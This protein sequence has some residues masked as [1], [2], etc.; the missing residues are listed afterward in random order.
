MI[1]ERKRRKKDGHTGCWSRGKGSC[2]CALYG[3]SKNKSKTT[4]KGDVRKRKSKPVV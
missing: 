2:A 4:K 1:R 3:G